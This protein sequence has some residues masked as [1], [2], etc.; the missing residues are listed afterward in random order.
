MK[1]DKGVAYI[2]FDRCL[3]EPEH[4]GI[5]YKL[6]L[7]V[8]EG[9]GLNINSIFSG[10][11]FMDPETDDYLIFDT[12]NKKIISFPPKVAFIFEENE[13]PG[14]SAKISEFISHINIDYPVKFQLLPN[15]YSWICKLRNGLD[16][17]ESGKIIY[18][19]P[20]GCISTDGYKGSLGENPTDLIQAPHIGFWSSVYYISRPEHDEVLEWLRLTE[21]D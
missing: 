13:D 16:V 9:R 15:E 1:I 10:I 7:D 12:T 20:F 21:E 3:L 18:E 14:L 11:I 6:S 2:I 4:V 5:E 19:A 8:E 17:I